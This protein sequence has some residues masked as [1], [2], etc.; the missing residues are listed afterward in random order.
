MA[1][2]VHGITNASGSTAGVAEAVGGWGGQVGVGH[3]GR[4]GSV[5]R[6]GVEIQFR[7]EP[8]GR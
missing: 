6:T 2:V 4:G 8:R 7:P 3:R 1:A 5:G